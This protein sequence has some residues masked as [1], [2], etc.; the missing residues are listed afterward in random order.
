MHDGLKLLAF[1]FASAT[2][3]QKA[4]M[5]NPGGAVS[6]TAGPIFRFWLCNCGL[7]VAGSPP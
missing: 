3:V 7:A 4:L 5:A 1:V 6:I 2:S